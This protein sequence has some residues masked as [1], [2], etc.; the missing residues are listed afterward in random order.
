MIRWLPLRTIVLTLAATSSLA[1]AQYVRAGDRS[2]AR[3]AL[4]FSKYCALCHGAS[5]TGDGRASALQKVP[6]A[7]LTWSTQPRSYKLQIVTRGGADMGRSESMPAWRE[8][9]SEAE[10][11]DVVSYVETLRK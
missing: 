8:V 2:A 4:V 9:L 3:G 10:I 11:Q 5:G 6:P 1:A 7:N